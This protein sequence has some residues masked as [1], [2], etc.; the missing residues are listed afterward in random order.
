[1]RL[2]N[3][4]IEKLANMDVELD[5]DS[6]VKE[7]QVFLRLINYGSCVDSHVSGLY[8]EDGVWYID[9]DAYAGVELNSLRPDQIQVCKVVNDWWGS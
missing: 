8:E 6:G 1:M 3:E 2:T 9:T 5:P 7:G 4:Q